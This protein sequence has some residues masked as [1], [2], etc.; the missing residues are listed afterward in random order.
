MHRP[1]GCQESFGYLISSFIKNNPFIETIE[2]LEE[3][4]ITSKRIAGKIVVQYPSDKY[5]NL[6]HKTFSSALDNFINCLN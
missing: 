2:E 6:S 5:L 1:P 4:L 3:V